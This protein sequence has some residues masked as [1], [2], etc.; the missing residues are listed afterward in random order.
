MITEEEKSNLKR[1]FDAIRR[2]NEP[3]TGIT[4]PEWYEKR[5]AAKEKYRQLFSPA[6]L[7]KLGKEEF[8][9]FLYFENNQSWTGLYRRGTEAAE[10]NMQGLK[11]AI[12]YLQN[13]SIDIKTRINEVLDGRL[14]V[15]GMGKNLAT[16]IL[17]VC[18]NQDKY[19]VWNNMVEGTLELLGLLPRLTTNRGESYARINEIL[20]I[21]KTELN[22]D[23][24][25]V[26]CFMYMAREFL[27]GEG[28]EI[29]TRESPEGVSVSLEKDLINFLAK[30]ISLVG[31]G[32]QRARA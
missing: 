19:G 32:L 29:T 3:I 31:S 16:A 30:N 27:G 20:N 25:Y 2:M 5:K 4:V 13:E 21:I 10:K 23:L 24:V 22:T 26:D 7:G 17:Q 6:N 1:L 8:M 12:A 28:A 14:A 9:T 11:E 18:D 15:R